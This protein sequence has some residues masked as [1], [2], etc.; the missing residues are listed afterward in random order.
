MPRL[1]ERFYRGR[2]ADNYS[3]SGAGLG[4]A[5]CKAVVE[6]MGGHIT[7]ESQPQEGATFTIW[8]KAANPAV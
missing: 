3:T 5:I 4:L 7:V 1:F 8:L 6:K 2:A